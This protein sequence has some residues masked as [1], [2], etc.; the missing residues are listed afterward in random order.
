MPFVFA[1]TSRRMIP[2]ARQAVRPFAKS[3]GELV[4]AY[5]FAHAS[6]GRF[7]ARVVQENNPEFGRAI[8]LALRMDSAQHDILIAALEVA[9]PKDRFM[10]RVVKNV[11]WAAKKMDGATFISWALM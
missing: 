7:F 10:A 3:V 5:N 2:Q 9:K 6:L 11:L 8:W 4:W 1:K